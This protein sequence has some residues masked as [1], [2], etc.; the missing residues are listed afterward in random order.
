MCNW[1][2]DSESCLRCLGVLEIAQSLNSNTLQTK[3]LAYFLKSRVFIL[4]LSNLMVDN[5]KDLKYLET[6]EK[7][8]LKNLTRK[9]VSNSTFWKYFKIIYLF[10]PSS[11]SL[12]FKVQASWNNIGNTIGRK[13]LFLNVLTSLQFRSNFLVGWNS[14]YFSSDIIN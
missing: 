3:L 14:R 9:Y 13:Q 12:L 7:I 4:S 8:L 6:L 2:K 11:P 10:S 1:D 5:L